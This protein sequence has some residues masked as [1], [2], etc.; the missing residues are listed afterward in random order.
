MKSEAR[1]AARIGVFVFSAFTLLIATL[2]VISSG[3]FFR[4]SYKFVVYFDSTLKGLVVGAP[5]RLYGVQVG[6]V[7]SI[8]IV[9]DHE[10]KTYSLPIII[11]LDKDTFF[12][13]EGSLFSQDDAEAFVQNY[14]D[15]GLRAEL[16]SESLVSGSLYIELNFLTPDKASIATYEE[17]HLPQYNDIMQIPTSTTALNAVLDSIAS[18]PFEDVVSHIDAL[19]LQISQLVTNIDKVVQSEEINEILVAYTSLANTVIAE[20]NEFGAIRE[21]LDTLITSLNSTVDANDEELN[22][23]LVN[24]TNLSKTADSFMLDLS[25][26][27]SEDS[28]TMIEITKTMQL[29]QSASRGVAELTDILTQHPES[30]IY[31]KE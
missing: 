25:H 27:V 19:I 2:A 20:V 1:R 17:R 15:N 8:Q 21:S 9:N 31:G 30:L 4:E 16:Q 12:A 5:V 22:T 26:V 6:R 29:L 14:I 23:L 24:L 7:S 13:D 18:I 11:D 3:T 10:A 28:N